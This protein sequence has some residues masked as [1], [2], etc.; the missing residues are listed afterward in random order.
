MKKF[1]LGLLAGSLLTGSIVTMAQ[2]IKNFP[3]VDVKAYY[4]S[5]VDTMNSLGVINGYDN[6]N[7][8][9]DDPITRAQAAVMF[10]RYDDTLKLLIQDYCDN[11]K[12]QMGQMATKDYQ[13]LCVNR[14]Y[15]A[16]VTPPANLQ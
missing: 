16:Y 14:G 4:T 5:A 7:F 12:L 13:D 15:P 10:Q 9:P 6:G 3:D 8:G 2:T 1:L 11:H